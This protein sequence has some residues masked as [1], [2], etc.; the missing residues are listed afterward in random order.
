MVLAACVMHMQ[1]THM[2]AAVATQRECAHVA[3]NDN[4]QKMLGKL[5]VPNYHFTAI[6]PEFDWA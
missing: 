5:C 1:H 2:Q 6:S 3:I 4:L